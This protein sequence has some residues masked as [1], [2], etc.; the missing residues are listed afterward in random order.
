MNPQLHQVHH[1]TDP[2]STEVQRLVEIEPDSWFGFLVASPDSSLRLQE[3]S[4]YEQNAI[5]CC[6]VEYELS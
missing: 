6:G 4:V 5:S 1:H 2:N 3:L